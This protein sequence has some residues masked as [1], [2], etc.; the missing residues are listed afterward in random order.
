MSTLAEIEEA[1]EALPLP[2]Q[3]TLWR[4]LSCRLSVRPSHEP[5]GG[6]ERRAWLA[7]LRQVRERNVTGKAGAPLQQVMDELRGER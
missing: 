4:R 5:Q 6:A 3:E 1:V 2:D 7:E